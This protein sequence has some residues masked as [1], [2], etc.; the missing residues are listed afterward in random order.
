[1]IT[2]HCAELS[3]SSSKPLNPPP[4]QRGGGREL[5]DATHQ[6][7]RHNRGTQ[8]HNV[9]NSCHNNNQVSHNKAQQQLKNI[10]ESGDW[11][12]NQRVPQ[13]KTQKEASINRPGQLG[14]T[15]TSSANV[16][17]GPSQ[18]HHPRHQHKGHHRSP[19]QGTRLD[20]VVQP[21]LRASQERRGRKK[22]PKLEVQLEVDR[23]MQHW[24]SSSDDD[25]DDDEA[26]D[27]EVEEEIE[28]QPQPSQQ[29][30]EERIS[31][32]RRMSI[33]ALLN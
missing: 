18:L 29:Q 25:D 13:I 27:D 6:Q 28:E 19:F 1:M 8:E 14:Y 4:Q 24:G 2:T 17:C 15:P 12:P 3:S 5:S 32:E 10:E 9:H 22:K 33:A 21:T 26:T 30:E 11:S 16:G 20:Y 7:H 31:C 23:V